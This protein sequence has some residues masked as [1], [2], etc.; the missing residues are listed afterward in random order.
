MAIQTDSDTTLSPSAWRLDASASTVENIYR[1]LK[2][3]IMWGRIEPDTLL[4]ETVLAAR[5]GVSRTPVREALSMLASDGLTHALPRRGH[6]VGTVS[7]AETLEAFRVREILEVEAISHAVHRLS[8]AAIARLLELANTRESEDFPAIN[9]EFHMSIARASGNR[10][11]ADFIERLLVTMQR[12][13]ILDPHV[14]GWTEDGMQED[15]AI[16]RALAARDEA[17]ACE[18]MAVHIRNTL[19]SILGGRANH[20]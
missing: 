13:L 16:V 4:N 12:V 3:D 14:T 5:F 17:A 6:L 7:V 1:A 18:A 8:D 15:L 9:R 20:N 10:I 11:L 2:E 19:S